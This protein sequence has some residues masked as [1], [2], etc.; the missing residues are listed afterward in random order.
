MGLRAATLPDIYP[1]SALRCAAQPHGPPAHR[2]VAA[3][4][5]GSIDPQPAHRPGADRPVR[6]LTPKKV[7]YL[8]ASEM[9]IY[10][11]ANASTMLPQYPVHCGHAFAGRAHGGAIPPDVCRTPIGGLITSQNSRRMGKG[12]FTSLVIKMQRRPRS[13]CPRLGTMAEIR[14]WNRRGGQ[15]KNSAVR[16]VPSQ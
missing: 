1:D 14:Y 4:S 15:Q 10:L 9:Q 6:G 8:Y 12:G 7:R 16:T 11:H 13:F 5:P 2:L 3:R